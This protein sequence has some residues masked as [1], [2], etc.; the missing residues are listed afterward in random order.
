MSTWA[1]SSLSSDVSSVGCHIGM[2]KY[3]TRKGHNALSRV[4]NRKN[5]LKMQIYQIMNIIVIIKIMNIMINLPQNRR[6]P[7]YP[8]LAASCWSEKVH[9]RAI[10]NM[11]GKASIKSTHIGQRIVNVGVVRNCQRF[12]LGIIDAYGLLIPPC[13]GLLVVGNKKI[14]ETFKFGRKS[15]K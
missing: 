5:L 15:A 3:L 13:P 8:V 4:W 12:C 10:L 11:C 6:W 9:R 2:S 1:S 7:F 14:A